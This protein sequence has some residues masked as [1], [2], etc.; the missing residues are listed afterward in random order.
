MS[1]DPMTQAPDLTG[2]DSGSFDQQQSTNTHPSASLSTSTPSASISNNQQQQQQQ[3]H[4]QHASSAASRALVDDD[5]DVVLIG[6]N[7]PSPFNARA[8]PYISHGGGG[9]GSGINI[10]SSGSPSIGGGGAGVAGGGAGTRS[11]FASQPDS[12]NGSAQQQQQR[13]GSVGYGGG[14]VGSPSPL[15]RSGT[16][17]GV[18]PGTGAGGAITSPRAA[19]AQPGIIHPKQTPFSPE[20]SISPQLLLRQLDS[21]SGAGAGAQ[22]QTANKPRLGGGPKLPPPSFA[23]QLQR[24]QAG[25]QQQQHQQQ[26]QTT[27]RPLPPP[28]FAPI[29]LHRP[30]QPA[31]SGSGS[32][33][34]AAGGTTGFPPAGLGG[35]G[36]VGASVRKESPIGAGP[37]GPGSLRGP[38]PVPETVEP[39]P[40]WYDIAGAGADGGPGHGHGDG[41]GDDD[42]LMGE[43]RG[44]TTSTSAAAAAG[45]RNNGLRASPSMQG[46]LTPSVEQD[47][48]LNLEHTTSSNGVGVGLGMDVDDLDAEVAGMTNHH[49][50]VDVDDDV[51][52]L[53]STAPDHAHSHGHAHGHMNGAFSAAAAAATIPSSALAGSQGAPPSEPSISYSAPIPSYVPPPAQRVP[54]AAAAAA[55]SSGSNGNGNGNGAGL[56]RSSQSARMSQPGGAGVGGSQAGGGGGAAAAARGVSI[57]PIADGRR[58]APPDGASVHPASLVQLPSAGAQGL[59]PK[60][61]Y[62]NGIAGFGS[63]GLTGAGGSR[64]VLAGG[65]APQAQAQAQVQAAQVQVQPQ[66]QVVYVPLGGITGLAYDSTM[67]LHKHPTG[68]HPEQPSRIAKIF[69]LMKTRGCVERMRRVSGR[70]VLE[71]EVRLVHSGSVWAGVQNLACES[72]GRCAHPSCEKS[73]LLT[74][75]VTSHPVRGLHREGRAAGGGLVALR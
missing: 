29:S 27:H 39:E 40:V 44:T 71:E 30:L 9:G 49:D 56:A 51:F 16:S 69:K 2:L 66:T 18:G 20:A 15:G 72:V 67:M 24:P 28:Q 65:L 13:Q 53:H 63:S 17:P 4:L 62:A 37:A 6:D 31:G 14:A 58:Q 70:P 38:P 47:G 59:Y 68:E 3:Q 11:P 52:P 57:G 10:N 50:D 54:T 48:F 41:H 60:P 8:R 19:R 45:G 46:Y 33:S 74:R 12:S 36:G 21:G 25:A 61:S 73:D 55:N 64:E 7:R 75:H 22:Q 5:S 42:I 32:G 1:L 43:G 35:A 34:A 26:Q 23:A